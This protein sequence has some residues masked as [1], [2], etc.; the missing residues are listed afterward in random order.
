MYFG[1]PRI[2]LNAQALCQKVKKVILTANEDEL[3]MNWG[4]IRINDDRL[5]QW[6]RLIKD[7]YACQHSG[8]LQDIFGIDL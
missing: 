8:I 1:V 5:N 2:F 7:R 3:A 4:V 6:I